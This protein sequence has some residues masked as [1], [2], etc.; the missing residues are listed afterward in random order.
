LRSPGIGYRQDTSTVAK[1]GSIIAAR[2]PGDL[3]AEMHVATRL[4]AVTIIVLLIACAN[5]VNLLL[6]RAVNRRREIAVRI[7]LGVSRRRLVRMLVTESVLL[8]MLATAAAVVAASWGGALLRQLLVPEVRFA[9]APLHWRV[10]AFALVAALVSGALAGL[11]PAL[12]SASP[13]LIAALK[14]GSRDGGPHRSHLRSALVMCQ[15]ALSVVLMVGAVLFVRSLHNVKAH[16]VGY[17]VDRLAFASVQYDTKD[18][19]RDARV[20]AR[21]RALESRIAAIAGVE[22]V[23]FTSMRPKWGMTFIDYLPDIDTT[24]RRMPEGIFTVVSPGYFAATGTKL[25]RGRTF[26]SEQSGGAPY[27][28]IVNQA[29]A[30]AIWP[31]QDPIGH[32]VHFKTSAAPCAT[33]IGVAQT[34]LLNSIGERPS[35]HFY[36]S[37]DHPPLTTWGVSA[38]I[39]NADPARLATVQKTVFALLRAEFPGATPALTS[40]ATAMEPEY[41]P[42]QLGATLFTLFSGLALLVAAIGIYSTVSYA[43]SQRTHEFGV[44]MALGARAPDV[45]RHV[46]GKGLSTVTAGIVIGILMTLAAGHFVASLLYGIA[47]SDP[48][49]MIAVAALLLGVASLAALAPAWRAAKADPVAALRAD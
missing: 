15:A 30:D 35:P 21:L 46:L 13:D 42:W 12:Q 34:A 18:S 47:P 4:A 33:V 31:N 40:M 41:R 20:P 38:V 1:F 8:A 28:V 11:V 23:A 2:G 36:L 5:V 25:V 10:L 16:D 22:H 6:A 7:A 9:Q 49:A 24:G 3:K 48:F 14:A 27:A 32:C 43:V 29:M 37:L 44:R 17:A 45:V 19:A 26:D 39:V